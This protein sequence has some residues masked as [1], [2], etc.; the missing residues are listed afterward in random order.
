MLESMIVYARPTRAECSDVAN[1]VLDGTDAVML[2]GE[3]ASGAHP[4]DAVRYMCRTCVE[5]ESI[6]NYPALFAA[7][8]EST[9]ALGHGMSVQEAVASSAVKTVIDCGAKAIIVVSESGNSARLLAK[10]RP[11]VPILCLT[12]NE[13]VARN[14]AGLLRGVS[15]GVMGSTLGTDA[16]LLRSCDKL[17]EWG[18]VKSGDV[19][20]AVHGNLEGVPGSTNLCR[21]ITVE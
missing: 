18:W 21:A 20:V 14:A 4:F 10:Y 7:V 12:A 1:A 13:T 9:L 17:K 3:T 19:I 8:R 6:T 5:A 11:A 15:A 16:L 2:S